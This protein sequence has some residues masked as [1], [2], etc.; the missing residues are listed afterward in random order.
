MGHQTA[1]DRQS[2]IQPSV[3]DGEE[4]EDTTTDG[5]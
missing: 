4:N 1:S 3:S 5:A 2:I